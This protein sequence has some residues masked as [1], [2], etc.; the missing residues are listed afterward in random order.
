[1]PKVKVYAQD[2]N[3]VKPIGASITLFCNVSGNPNPVVTWI[4]N[5][6]TIISSPDGIRVSLSVI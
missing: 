2:N 3:S 5:E 1:M 4:L 6:Q